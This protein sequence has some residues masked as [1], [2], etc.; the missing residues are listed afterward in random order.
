MMS[1]RAQQKAESIRRTEIEDNKNNGRDEVKLGLSKKCTYKIEET[2]LE[3]QI[4]MTTKAK[5]LLTFVSIVHFILISFKFLSSY[6]MTK[7]TPAEK[8][9]NRI[10]KV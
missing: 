8:I 5:Y 10:G 4:K 2:P 6:V 3:K 7:G 1:M 9:L